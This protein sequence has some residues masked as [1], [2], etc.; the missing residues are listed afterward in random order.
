MVTALGFDYFTS[1]R[2]FIGLDLAGLA[3]PKV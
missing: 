2:I 1:V 3:P